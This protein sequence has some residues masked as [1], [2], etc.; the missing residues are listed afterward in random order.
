MTIEK[1]IH[2]D[3][4]ETVIVYIDGV[5][6]GSM[7]IGEWSRIIAKPKITKEEAGIF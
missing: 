2:L 3:G 4:R 1:Y 6:V 7:P 5:L